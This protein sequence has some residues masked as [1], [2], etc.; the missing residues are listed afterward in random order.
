MKQQFDRRSLVYIAVFGA[1][2]GLAEATIGTL[3]HIL[4]IPLAGAIL[5]SIGMGIVLVARVFNNRWGSTLTMAF[6]ASSIKMLSFSTV[7]LGPFLAI[8]VEGLFLELVFCIVG[9]GRLAFVLSAL[10]IAVYPIMQNIFTKS[11]LFG[12][13]FVLIILDLAKGIS[14]KIGYQAGWLM[15]GIYV[16]LHI[17]ISTFAAVSS[18]F[19][20]KRLKSANR[21]MPA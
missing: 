15:L 10:L 4:H 17:I 14:D 20:I 18:W 16:L 7:K 2:W 19:I 11:I 8:L 1:L 6:I 3:L 12:Q 21:N 9:N 5:G 13:S